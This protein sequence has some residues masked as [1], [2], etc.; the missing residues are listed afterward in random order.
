[1]FC[2]FSV[3]FFLNAHNFELFFKQVTVSQLGR[4]GWLGGSFLSGQAA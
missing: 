1:M 2:E 3:A 4:M